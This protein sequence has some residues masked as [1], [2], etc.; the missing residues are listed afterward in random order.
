MVRNYITN[1]QKFKLN[2]EIRLASK[3]DGI[4]S[5]SA[6]YFHAR[7]HKSYDTPTVV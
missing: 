7:I 1:V 6:G 5:V 3:N 4:L 2:Y